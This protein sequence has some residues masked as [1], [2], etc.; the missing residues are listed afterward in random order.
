MSEAAVPQRI[1]R[2]NGWWGVAIFVATEATLFGI[3]FGTYFYIRFQHDVWPPPGIPKPDVAVPLILTAVLV[4]TSIPIQLAL[5]AARAGRVKAARWLLAVPMV[6]QLGY[7]AMQIRL[8]DDDLAKF[9]PHESAYGS[10]YYLLLGAHHT[11]VVIGILLE[12]F[13]FARLLKGITAYRLVGLQSTA[14]Y[15]HF[16]NVLAVAVVAVELSAA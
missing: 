2:P 14:F 11:H 6:V 15:W 9:G 8:F 12:V 10:V 7:F 4:A 13:L 1:A 3:I 5:R 16:V